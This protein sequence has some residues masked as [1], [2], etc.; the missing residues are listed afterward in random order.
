MDAFNAR[1][2]V[3]ML[4]AAHTVLMLHTPY[5]C[6]IHCTNMIHLRHSYMLQLAHIIMQSDAWQRLCRLR[7][8]IVLE[9]RSVAAAAEAA[10]SKK[11]VVHATSRAK[12]FVKRLLEKTRMS[13]A[14][15]RI[16]PFVFNRDLSSLVQQTTHTLPTT[17]FFHPLR[18][19]LLQ[20]TTEM[21]TVATSVTSVTPSPAI[22]CLHTHCESIVRS[23][24]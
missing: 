1:S 2:Y 15:V 24:Q 11:D 13:N 9:P 8:L 10:F 19:C 21:G 22:T 16:P 3:T 18:H 5:S 12:G 23:E 14:V 4:P 17:N 6:C 20:I 7:V